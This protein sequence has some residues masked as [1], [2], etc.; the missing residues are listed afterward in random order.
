MQELNTMA[1]LKRERNKHALVNLGPPRLFNK[2]ISFGPRRKGLTHE[3]LTKEYFMDYFRTM[4]LGGI[5][6]SVVCWQAAVG[7]TTK[8]NVTVISAQTSADGSSEIQEKLLEECIVSLPSPADLQAD[9]V[10][11][12]QYLKEINGNPDKN[13]F[14]KYFSA[15]IEINYLVRQKSLIIITSRSIEAQQP[16]MKEVEKSIRHS[17]RFESNSVN[18]DLYA[19]HSNRQYYFS[20]AEGAI[21]DAKKRAETWLKQQNAVVCPHK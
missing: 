19:G 18:G 14:I 21:A 10:S 8:K 2:R 12:A 1:G 20:T 15:T 5:M 11:G 6:L 13:E 16:V 17:I 4:A 9:V 7:E 3:Q